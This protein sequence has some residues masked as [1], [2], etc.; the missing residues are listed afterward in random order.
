[1]K[2]VVYK[3]D[4]SSGDTYIG[5]PGRTLEVPLKEH[6]RSVQTQ[7]STNGIAVHKNQTGHDIEWNSAQVLERTNVV[8]KEIHRSTPDPLTQLHLEHTK[9]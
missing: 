5:E 7:L 4:C 8:E 2:G 3:V 6:K 1:M 9:Q